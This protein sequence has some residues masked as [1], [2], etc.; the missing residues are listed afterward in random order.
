M[1]LAELNQPQVLQSRINGIDGQHLETK[2]T[3]LCLLSQQREAMDNLAQS[4]AN[5]DKSLP[6]FDDAWNFLTQYPHEVHSYGLV[7]R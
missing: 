3:D 7:R 5:R 4:W 1:S 6:N 2:E